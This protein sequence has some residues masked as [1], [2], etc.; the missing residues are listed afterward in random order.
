MT[1]NL[2]VAP[3]AGPSRTAA[4]RIAPV[5]DRAVIARAARVAGTRTTIRCVPA[6]PNPLADTTVMS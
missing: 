2:T 3:S 4:R 6:E 1:R 5:S